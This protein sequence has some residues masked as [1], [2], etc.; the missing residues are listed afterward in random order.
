MKNKP[1]RIYLQVGEDNGD[2]NFNGLSEVT[3]SIGRVYGSDL[4][5]INIEESKNIARQLIREEI[6]RLEKIRYIDGAESMHLHRVIEQ[7]SACRTVLRLLSR[8]NLKSETSA[9]IKR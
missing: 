8:E 7:L 9:K 6:K 2:E 3:W 4:E 5:Y 1:K